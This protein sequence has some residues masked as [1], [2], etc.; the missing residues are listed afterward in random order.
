MGLTKSLNRTRQRTYFGAMVLS[1][2]RRQLTLLQILRGRRGK[3]GSTALIVTWVSSRAIN[4]VSR[5]CGGSVSSLLQFA[6]SLQARI[7]TQSSSSR[8]ELT[9]KSTQGAAGGARA[10]MSAASSSKGPSPDLGG[11]TKPPVRLNSLHEK[12]NDPSFLSQDEPGFQSSSRA[13]TGQSLRSSSGLP[14]STGGP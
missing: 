8:L 1:H 12:F 9:C 6:G 14:P 3:Q 2:G 7:P 10:G 5:C 13:P 11:P 4:F